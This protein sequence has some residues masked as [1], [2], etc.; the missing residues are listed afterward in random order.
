MSIQ[1]FPI[2]TVNKI[3]QYIQSALLLTDAEQQSQIWANLDEAAEPPEPESLDDLSGLFNFG[4]LTPEEIA[5]PTGQWRISTVNPADAIVKLPGLWLK[6]GF[7][8]VSF[9][10]RE[11]EFGKGAVFAVPE[12][13]S[14]TAWLEQAIA[15][16]QDIQPLIPEGASPDLMEVIDG[17]R[18]AASFLLASLLRRE[19][20][21]FGAAGKQCD[22]SCH[23]VIDAIPSQV[24][25]HW[26]GNPPKDLAPK[27]KLL[28]DSQAA[29]EFFT[30]RIQAP[31]AIFRHVDQYPAKQ[32]KG[33][34]FDKAIAGAYRY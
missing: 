15:K 9:V 31:I 22:W 8:L 34:S 24:K 32:Y 16:S 30:C 28:P 3:R 5:L 26:Q 10:C 11:K 7:R 17:D 12:A 2:A 19:L 1:K 20:K 14:T 21:E 13:Y 23:R 4:G 25:W 27:V 6:P 29:T 33:S 18:S